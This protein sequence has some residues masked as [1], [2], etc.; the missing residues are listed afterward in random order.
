LKVVRWLVAEGHPVS[1]AKLVQ[2][3][4]QRQENGKFSFKLLLF[5]KRKG[6][7]TF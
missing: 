4:E 7:I 1:W 2:E 5:L 6:V 3:Q